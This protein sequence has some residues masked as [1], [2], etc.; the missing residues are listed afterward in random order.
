MNMHGTHPRERMADVIDMA[1]NQVMTYKRLAE[2]LGFSEKSAKSYIDLL[3]KKAHEFVSLDIEIINKSVRGE[4][5][6]IRIWKK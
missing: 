5:L 4:L 6:S 1:L 3:E 2:E